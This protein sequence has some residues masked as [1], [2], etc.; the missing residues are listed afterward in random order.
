MKWI[1]KQFSKNAE[2]E[3]FQNDLKNDS[4]SEIENNN[5]NIIDDNSNNNIDKD[6]VEL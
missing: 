1:L 3:K 2:M 5:N 6:D 4:N